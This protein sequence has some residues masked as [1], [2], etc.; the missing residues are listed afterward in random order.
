MSKKIR[1]TNT[2]ARTTKGGPGFG[3]EFQGHYIAAN[4]PLVIDIPVIPVILEDWQ[5][6]GW[7]RIEDA[8]AAPLSAPGEAE[9]TPGT[10]VAEVSATEVL[11]VV[12]GED[13]LL[14]EEEFDLAIAKEATM[15]AETLTVGYD[16]VS[17]SL[18][19]TQETVSS[20]SLSPIP[21]DK[22]RHI[23]DAEKFTVRAP[24]ATAVG[25]IVKA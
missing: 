16:K 5:A 19:S 2:T 13:D 1:I 17:V 25:G 12:S 23:G 4:R 20:D 9:V 11:S 15:P 7:I 14:A 10:T 8:E 6:K 21:G 24:R 3:L 22:P 18:G